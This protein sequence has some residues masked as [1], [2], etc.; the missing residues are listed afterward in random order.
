MSW[1]QG[2]LVFDC[3]PIAGAY[4]RK[5]KIKIKINQTR[6]PDPGHGAV[7]GVASCRPIGPQLL[8]PRTRAR[9]AARRRDRSGQTGHAG[10]VATGR[11][12]RAGRQFRDGRA[13]IL[14]RHEDERGARPRGPAIGDERASDSAGARYRISRERSCGSPAVELTMPVATRRILGRAGLL[15]AWTIASVTAPW[16]LAGA[17]PGRGEAGQRAGEAPRPRVRVVA[18][19]FGVRG[20]VC[21]GGVACEG[22]GDDASVTALPR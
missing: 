15:F 14:P 8:S 4:V 6:G 1:P 18:R 7:T 2:Q 20:R 13:E 22:C 11:W 21:P 9:R 3:T 16:R 17:R 19:L 12:N 5:P 10:P